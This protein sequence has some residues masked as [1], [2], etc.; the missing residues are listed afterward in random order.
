VVSGDGVQ[1]SIVQ[2]WPRAVE[3]IVRS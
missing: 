3:P 2:K 1:N